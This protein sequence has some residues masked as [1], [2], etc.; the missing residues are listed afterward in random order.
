MPALAMQMSSPAERAGGVLGEC[1]YVLAGAD[2]E[3]DEGGAEGGVG[4]GVGGGV[5]GGGGGV[6]G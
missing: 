2:D 4:G 6:V 1:G 5:E 3:G